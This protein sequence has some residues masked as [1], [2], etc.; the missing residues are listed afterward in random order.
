MQQILDYDQ[1]RPNLAKFVY[2][3]EACKELSHLIV[4]D[5]I[6]LSWPSVNAQKSAL[7]GALKAA[8]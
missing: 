3:L 7:K 2:I 6:D 1:R 5:D 8:K 4:Y